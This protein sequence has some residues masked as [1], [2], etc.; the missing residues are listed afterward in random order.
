[1][2]SPNLITRL[3]TM[4]APD[5]P[6]DWSMFVRDLNEA[7]EPSFYS[8]TDAG[9]SITNGSGTFVLFAGWTSIASHGDDMT[10]DLSTGTWTVA[11][12]GDYKIN[13]CMQIQR[14]GTSE[15]ANISAQVFVGGTGLSPELIA[16]VAPL[17]DNEIVSVSRTAIVTLAVSD[18]VDLRYA[19]A[20]THSVNFN[21]ICMTIQRYW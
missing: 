17:T 4:E 5:T 6:Y 8:M 10:E 11:K 20:S 14:K 15:T 2:R 1:M 9:F 13:F 21:Q 3:R 19:V 18:V 12:P 16:T 7:L